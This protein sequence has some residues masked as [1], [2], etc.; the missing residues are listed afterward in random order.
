MLRGFTW[1]ET[2]PPTLEDVRYFNG[3]TANTEYFEDFLDKIPEYI[4][5]KPR[6]TQTKES[7]LPHHAALLV[8]VLGIVLFVAAMPVLFWV[9]GQAFTL[10]GESYIS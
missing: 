5:S 1:P 6:K 9:T 3:L 10:F 8:G 7:A 2:L 4:T